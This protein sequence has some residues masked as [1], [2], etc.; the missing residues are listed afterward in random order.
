[1]SAPS[2]AGGT[3][4]TLS[5]SITDLAASQPDLSIPAGASSGSFIVGTNPKF[6]RYSGLAFTVTITASANGSSKSAILSVT[7][8]PKPADINGDSTQRHGTVC[9][10]V[11]PARNGEGGILYQC[12]DGPDFG[13]VGKCTFKQECLSFG[14]QTKPSSNFTFVDVCATSAPYPITLAPS[15]VVGGNSSQAT[16][17]LNQPAPANGADVYFF[18]S[19]YQLANVPVFN[20]VEPGG[21]SIATTVTTTPVASPAFAAITVNAEN[22]QPSGHVGTRAGLRWLAVVPSGTCVPT[23][24]AA[25]GS[26]CGTISDGCGGT[27]SCGTCT[28]P[29]T[30]GGAGTPNV[31]GTC[32]AT[33]CAIEGKDCGTIADGCGGFLS[34]GTCT[35]P[36]TCGGAGTPNVCGCTAL[37]CSAQ[38]KNCGV[39]SD[40]CGGTLACGTCSAPQTCGGGG[41][42]NVCGGGNATLTVTATGRRRERVLSAPAG[43]N[44]AVGSSQ[45]ATFGVG[46]SITLSATNGRDVIWSGVCSSGGQKRKTCTFVLNGNSSETANVQ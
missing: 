22:P 13:T 40:S 38:G 43:I 25:Q 2:P 26:N 31:C 28:S 29:E 23:T 41:V 4:L 42:P 46:T 39:I 3:N 9:G 36:E 11:F 1:M 19:D 45:T 15:Y 17:F 33:S 21:T 18:S 16:A 44:V 12:F 20:H 30:C 37:S 6:R 32:A 34:C 10:S 14:C 35:S 24:C 7:A 8:Q 27:L 5:S